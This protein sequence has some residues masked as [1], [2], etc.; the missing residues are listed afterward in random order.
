MNDGDHLLQAIL[1]EPAD[2]LHRL[3][4][5]DWL[6]EHGDPDDHARAE[7]IR[8]Q[9]ELAQFRA[10]ILAS[11]SKCPTD[12][13]AS[14]CHVLV[15]RQTALLFD[16]AMLWAGGLPEILLSPEY[17]QAMRPTCEARANDNGG[18]LVFHGN[19]LRSQPCIRFRRGFVDKVRC[20]LSIWKRSGNL[21]LGEYP[22]EKVQPFD[23]RPL[24]LSDEHSQ[25]GDPWHGWYTWNDGRLTSEGNRIVFIK[26]R[27][28]Q[29]M[30]EYDLP[31]ELLQLVVSQ[32]SAGGA[33]TQNPY[34]TYHPSEKD[35]FDR[36][37]AACLLWAKQPQPA[38]VS[39]S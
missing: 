31:G 28:E 34:T 17:Y 16:Y 3:F 12:A 33:G 18:W 21:I 32:H 2:D 5:A 19:G 23:K 26:D 30:A 39:S 38:A 4:Y 37:S 36:L 8:V 25:P 6:E 24:A 29:D 14:R 10:T 27:R 20:R 7:F 11:E 13:Q 35:A 1:A 22:V 15:E 9:I